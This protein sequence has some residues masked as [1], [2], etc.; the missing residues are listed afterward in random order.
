MPK[1][2]VNQDEQLLLGWKPLPGNHRRFQEVSAQSHE[3]VWHI[4]PHKMANYCFDT[5]VFVR[6]K[7]TKYSVLI[8]KL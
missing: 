6:I 3:I 1:L 7:Q 4:N 2:N 8:S 5:T